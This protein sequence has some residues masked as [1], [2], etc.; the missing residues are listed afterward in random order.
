M[1]LEQIIILASGTISAYTDH[2][3]GEI[4]NQL[5]LPLIGLGIVLSVLNQTWSYFAIGLLV[6][7]LAT[8]A[9]Q[10][11]V[12]GGGDIKLLTGMALIQGPY[13]FAF[14]MLGGLAALTYMILKK[15][16]QTTL[17]PFL[18]I[19]VLLTYALLFL[20]KIYLA[21]LTGV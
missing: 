10:K 19:G 20:S 8:M 18:L 14:M 7:F 4:P 16:E 15:K 13:I 12:M 6:F 1:I 5:T 2:K 3:T 17:G 21:G 9:Y 11:N